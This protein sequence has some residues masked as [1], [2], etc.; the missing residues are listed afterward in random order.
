MSPEIFGRWEKHQKKEPAL[1]SLQ[2]H[3]L[4]LVVA[5]CWNATEWRHPRDKMKS[6]LPLLS[7]LPVFYACSHPGVCTWCTGASW[8]CC[9]PALRPSAAQNLVTPR[10][11]GFCRQTQRVALAYFYKSWKRSGVVLKLVNKTSS[12]LAAQRDLASWWQ[13]DNRHLLLPKHQGG[14]GAWATSPVPPVPSWVL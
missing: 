5:A 4:H 7:L 12:G 6:R 8:S 14:T 10:T 3:A 1:W 11:L 2:Q 9:R 13:Q